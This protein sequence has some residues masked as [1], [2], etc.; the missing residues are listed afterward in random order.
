MSM[1]GRNNRRSYEDEGGYCK[2]TDVCTIVVDLL[3]ASSSVE[4]AYCK[5]KL[6]NTRPSLTIGH[7]HAVY[8]IF[9]L[10]TQMQFWVGFV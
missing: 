2:T 3:T 8:M 7:M 9:D 5:A 1:F 10:G 6:V 4:I